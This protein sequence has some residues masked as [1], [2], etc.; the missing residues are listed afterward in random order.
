M[1]P[2]TDEEVFSVDVESP[3]V[4]PCVMKTRLDVLAV[5]RCFPPYFQL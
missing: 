5:D 3:R 2:L 4:I 1:L